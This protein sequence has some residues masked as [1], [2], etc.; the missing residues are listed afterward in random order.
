MS[1]GIS[2]SEY[3]KA[4]QRRRVPRRNIR[5]FH[6]GLDLPEPPEIAIDPRYENAYREQAEFL[7]QFSESLKVWRERAAEVLERRI[8][9]EDT[10]QTVESTV[11]EES[12][13]GNGGTTSS[14]AC[15]CEGKLSSVSDDSAAGAITFQK[16]PQ[17][18]KLAVKPKELIRK[19]EFDARV[20]NP[21]AP[22]HLPNG[23]DYIEDNALWKG[24]WVPGVYYKG[25]MVRAGNY[26]MVANKET[27]DQ[28][29]PRKIG[30]PFDV[31]DIP[32]NPGQ[33]Q[34]NS[35]SA[36]SLI[37]GQRYEFDYDVLVSEISY[38]VPYVSAGAGCEIFIVRDPA[39]SPVFTRIG[40]EFTVDLNDA[41]QW[42]KVSFPEVFFR[43]GSAFD[44]LVI[45]R[46]ATG[47][48][49]FSY[50]WSYV[51]RNGDPGQGEVVQQLGANQGDLRVHQLDSTLT[52]R[53]SDL[54]NIGPGS[55]ITMD[56]SGV[57]WE[58]M[59]SVKVGDVYHFQ[60]QPAIK[61]SDQVSSFTF[62]YY[63]ASSMSYSEVV[64]HWSATSEVDG[65]FSS[66][67]YDNIVLDDNLYGVDV[68]IQ[69]ASVSVD[70]NLL[71]CAGCCGAQEEDDMMEISIADTLSADAAGRL[72]VSNNVSRFES[73]FEFDSNPL[74]WDE[75]TSG[76][77]SITHSSN[78]S[79]VHLTC[80][81]ASG[82]FAAR[83]TFRYFK[84][85]PGKSD[86]CEL[87][88]TLGAPKINCCRRLGRFDDSNGVFLQSDG[89]G[90]SIVVRSQV[91]GV[92]VDTSYPRTSWN[93]DKMDGTGPSGIVVNWDYVQIF[94]FD[95]ESFETGRV[96]LYF[97]IGGR[98]RLVH[99]L[100]NANKM[101]SAY[102]TTLDLPLRF[103]IENTGTVASSTTVRQYCA[104]VSFEGGVE[105]DIGY[106][107]T[108]TT[109]AAY[110][111][112]LPGFPTI[113]PI[114]AIRPKAIFGTKI[115]RVRIVPLRFIATAT[116]KAVIQVIYKPTSFTGASWTSVDSNSAVEYDVSATAF[117]GG[118]VIANDYI[119]GDAARAEGIVDYQ[120]I[121]KLPIALDHS[122][123]NPIA[124][125][126]GAYSMD[127]P[128]FPADVSA[129]INWKEVR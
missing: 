1:N 82:D 62:V 97:V 10:V 104:H 47:D 124:L 66:T 8:P 90:I 100:E 64:N 106:P 54:N 119:V 110:K 39:G 108:A 20:P 11:P 71:S 99:V 105:E 96:R 19:Q 38:W 24:E 43:G 34:D 69:E 7:R 21:H 5:R 53:S 111:T 89:S 127:V 73:M 77:G 3:D 68:R 51:S 114:V 30:E 25:H 81:T 126:I 103:E 4:V 129:I 125:L 98:R 28:A 70:W 32:G 46:P 86:Y 45:L 60:V 26:V 113:T 37:F 59:S 75:W 23:S 42:T 123:S 58:V 33:L 67:G 41:G 120:K 79:G 48:V 29:T 116:A 95:F 121:I 2:S 14:V 101:E 80:G 122:G 50:N 102:I 16:A 40:P 92:V 15:S 17:S 12:G 63:S 31:R 65:F 18:N 76:G 61:S 56:A 6:S 88:G 72:R 55:R 13:S 35:V 74:L 128:A 36:S 84:A 52:D 22:S 78:E 117:T 44:V 93:Y 109:G 49:S 115:N 85:Q 118:I 94:G 112:A 27:G 107:F 9:E 91:T 57:S 83:Q 87:I